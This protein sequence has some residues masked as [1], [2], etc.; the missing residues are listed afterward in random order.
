MKTMACKAAIK[1]GEPLREQEIE[2]LL[3]DLMATENPY[4]CPH[5]QPIIVSISHVEM[6]RRFER[7]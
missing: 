5:G 4:I 3:K 2:A 6:D 7:T 1:A